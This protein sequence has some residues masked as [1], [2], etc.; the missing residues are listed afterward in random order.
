[1]PQSHIDF[2]LSKIPRGRFGTVDE[3]GKLGVLAGQ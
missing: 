1:M 2:M 3:S